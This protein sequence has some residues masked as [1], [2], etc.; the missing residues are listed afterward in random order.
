MLGVS[1]LNLDF[2]TNVQMLFTTFLM[3]G[4]AAVS[5]CSAADS[6]VLVVEYDLSNILATFLQ[7]Y[8]Y[9]QQSTIFCRQLPVLFRGCY[10][11]QVSSIA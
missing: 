10:L 5:L 7:Y 11:L 2:A 9:Y 3:V 6:T 8:F 4:I 1:G